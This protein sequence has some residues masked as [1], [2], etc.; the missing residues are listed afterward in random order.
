LAH[1]RLDP[2]AD[3]RTVNLYSSQSKAVMKKLSPLFGN[4]EQHTD[5]MEGHTSMTDWT[6]LSYVVVDVEGN[7][8]QPPDLVELAA[9]PVTAGMSAGRRAGW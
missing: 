8:Q 9:V 1:F 6:T 7:G 4:A 2:A 3:H 5:D